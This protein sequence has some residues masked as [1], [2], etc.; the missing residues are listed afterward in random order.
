MLDSKLSN[1]LWSEFAQTHPLRQARSKLSL[2]FTITLILAGAMNNIFY[3]SMLPC[4][5]VSVSSYDVISC[6]QSDTH[7]PFCP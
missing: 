2:K 7:I 6:F 4:E 1:L 3:T 5:V